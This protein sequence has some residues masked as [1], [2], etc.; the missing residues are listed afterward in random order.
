MRVVVVER[1]LQGGRRCNKNA[2]R[3]HRIR[4]LC[5]GPFLSPT[6]SATRCPLADAPWEPASG[7]KA[8]LARA[9]A[10]GRV[11]AAACSMTLLQHRMQPARH[12]M[13]RGTAM[14]IRLRI[15]SRCYVR[16]CTSP[17]CS[18]RNVASRSKWPC[19]GLSLDFKFFWLVVCC[20]AHDCVC[21][22][23]GSCYRWPLRSTAYFRSQLCDMRALR[24]SR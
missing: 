4:G 10:S 1:D 3:G 19:F 20:F 17:R 5:P 16:R 8:T 21:I 22:C 13:P 2:A 11:G 18:Y 24:L 9:D 6:R 23:T 15:S 12:H 14:A 7:R